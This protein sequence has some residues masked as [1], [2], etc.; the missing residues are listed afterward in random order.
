VTPFQT[1]IILFFT[2]LPALMA[3]G[4]LRLAYRQEREPLRWIG[5]AFLW[6]AF[7]AGLISRFVNTHVLVSL[8]NSGADRGESAFLGT[9]LLAPVVEE[10]TKGLFLVFLVSRRRL[11]GLP[12]GLLYGLVVGLGFASAENVGQ[13]GHLAVSSGE[14]AMW[15]ALL[16]RTVATA[17]LHGASAG[18]FGAML[19]YS[20]SVEK[21]LRGFFVFNGF[22]LASAVHGYWN[23]LAS[24]RGARLAGLID[25]VLAIYLVIL[26]LLVGGTFIYTLWLREKA[27]TVPGV[28]GWGFRYAA[29]WV[30]AGLVTIVAYHVVAEAEI[31]KAPEYRTAV[32]FVRYS[33][34]L[35]EVL[36]GR[37]GTIDYE[38]LRVSE[39]GGYGLCEIAFRLSLKDGL[40]DT[41]RVGLVKVADFWFVYQAELNPDEPRKAI[42][43]STYQKVLLFQQDIDLNDIASA[44]YF[45]EEIRKEN[46]DPTLMA[47]LQAQLLTADGKYD[48]AITALASAS[49]DAHYALPAIAYQKG[50]AEFGKG[51][52]VSAIKSLKSLVEAIATAQKKVSAEGLFENL[53]KDPFLAS[54][55]PRTI[56]ASSQKTLAL[57]YVYSK[58]YGQGLDWAEKA[59]AQATRIHSSVT[60]LNAVYVKALSL[61]YLQRY[62]DAEAAF[63]V[64]AIDI[65]NANLS[66][67]A[68]AYYYRG[69]IAA[70][71]SKHE[72]A[73]DNYEIAVS[74]DPLNVRIRSDAITYLINRNFAGDYEIA[75]GLAIRGMDYDAAGTTFQTL[76]ASLFA[77]LGLPDKTAQMP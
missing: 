28:W 15:N 17:L 42:V 52:Y 3:A 36:V 37:L 45:L 30:A 75:L 64:V 55:N 49:S 26:G 44:K 72:D 11:A 23:A 6:G 65:D 77:K 16:T 63:R 34:A 33:E 50:L 68:M 66:Q 62:E 53:P 70:H 71:A 46:S 31:K 4:L 73:L 1:A 35:Q 54:V 18:I 12:E 59:I 2:Y 9:L 19:G 13:A 60:R 74:L 8:L 48:V 29:L 67:R 22:V 39:K 5:L 57:A 69:Y 25:G 40:S 10:F 51:D 61:F 32:Q 43:E 27:R 7:G 58:D 41:L 38:D 24:A 76:A 56:L 20:L 14:L 21:R 47:F